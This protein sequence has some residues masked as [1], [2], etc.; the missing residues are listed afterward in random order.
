MVQLKL[1]LGPWSYCSQRCRRLEVSLSR[2]RI[3][4]TRL[5]HGYLMAREIPRVYENCQV[6]LPIS[7][8]LVLNALLIP[9]PVIGFTLPRHQCLPVSVCL[10]SSP[11]RLLFAFLRMS[12]LMSDL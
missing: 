7:H 6:H 4:D 12:G 9:C 11:S 2:L 8:I 10:F 5:T 1:S 3:G